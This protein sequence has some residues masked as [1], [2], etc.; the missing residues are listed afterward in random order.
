LSQPDFYSQ[1][2]LDEARTKISKFYDSLKWEKKPDFKP[3]FYTMVA[4]G[5][6]QEHNPQKS[7]YICVTDFSKPNTDSRLFIINL[8]TL[9]VEEAL[10][11]W[12]WKNSWKWKIPDKF[13]NKKWS[14]QS[15]LWAFKTSEKL[16]WNTK[17]TWKWLLL[18]WMEDSNYRAES[19]WIF[20]HPWGVN[21]SEWCFTIPYEKDKEEVYNVLQKLEW[22]CLVY[23]YFDE[24]SL[25]DSWIVSPSLRNVLSMW[26]IWAHNVWTWLKSVASKT[27]A[28]IE[29]IF[30][31]NRQK[32][33]SKNHIERKIQKNE[34]QGNI[35]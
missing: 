13:S 29:K 15:S 26:K 5:R 25:K 7:P 12:H 4:Y 11:V 16:Q 28:R 2:R 17:W 33:L 31:G 3:F 34:H 14:L 22:W 6:I 30:S 32:K 35:A 24:K 18:E 9:Q 20:M 1:N 10:C 8:N 27:K 21:Q 23:S 19:R